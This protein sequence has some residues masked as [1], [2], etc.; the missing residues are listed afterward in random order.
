MRAAILFL[1][2]I[3]AAPTLAAPTI[4]G[5]SGALTHGQNVTV[6]GSAFGSRP[7]AAPLRSD[8]FEAGT[9]GQNLTGWNITSTLPSML[10]EYAAVARPGTPGGKSALE[11]FGSGNYNSGIGV[12]N[13]STK[14]WYVSGWVKGTTSGSPS[15]NVKLVSFRGPDLSDPEGRLDQYP[16]NGSGHIYTA[17]CNGTKTQ[18]S[19]AIQSNLIIEDGGWHRFEAWI[20]LGTPNGGNGLYQVWKDTATWGGV[21]SGTM[22]TS[23]CSFSEVHVQHYYATDTGTAPAANY[24]WD[25]LYIDTSRARIEIGNASTWAASNHRE[26]QTTSAWSS[27]GATFK[28][29]R[30]S[31]A[32]GS[33]VYLFV[34]DDSGAASAGYPV[35]IAADGGGGTSYTVTPSAGANGSISPNTAQTVSSGGTAGFTVT[36]SGGYTASVAGSCPTGSL[37]GTAYTT[38]AITANCTVD[39]TFVDTTAPTTPASLTATAASTT[40]INL[41]WGASADGAGLVGYNIER[42]AGA[43]CTNWVEIQS[44]TGTGTT[45]NNT[46]LTP[47]TTYRYRV[48]ARD[49]A[50]NYSGYS[51]IASATTTITYTVTGT[52]DSNGTVSPASQTVNSGATTTLTVTPNAGY[53]AS[54]SGCGGSL[55]GTTYTT[56]AITANCTVSATFADTTAPSVAITAPAD[57]ST[58]AGSIAVSAT[59][60]DGVGVVGVQFKMDGA[61]LGA[62]DT[63]APHSITW[64][65]TGASDGAH[66]LTATARDAASN[67][68][69]G[70]TIAVIVDNTPPTVSDPQ[71]NGT[72]ARGATSV[73]ITVTTS[74]TAE[75]RRSSTAG[76]AW[77]SGTAYAATNSTTHTGT[78]P[79]TPG[80][81]HRIYTLCRD[82][83]GNQSTQAVAAFFVPRKPM[84]KVW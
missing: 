60:T 35:T 80:R 2:S 75:C 79:A 37:V 46:G 65:T 7:S 77:A 70:P 81:N 23:D 61:N 56:N 28:L 12:S 40:Q 64:A 73:T 76:F 49:A 58:V 36:P 45:Y 10:P 24:W 62:E 14:K 19:W 42:C 67:S 68:A 5:T 63:S 43:T 4:S 13:H 69:T 29:N 15:R 41:S 48:R 47:N 1:F 55:V 26:L 84:H 74:E 53:T 66:A 31:F 20:D 51:N 54:A 17:D 16:N 18:D 38:G 72:L 34:V 71:P 25:E 82:P 83:V 39:A 3:L 44:T 21:L 8:D 30:G 78:V 9:V 33:S 32:P 59:A 27:T 11:A 52:A 6:S 57:G 22:I 50:P